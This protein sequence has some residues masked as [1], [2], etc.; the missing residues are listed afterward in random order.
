[1]E[2]DSDKDTEVEIYDAPENHLP[3]MLKSKSR[4]G[5]LLRLPLANYL[6][7]QRGVPLK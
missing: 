5:E 7:F 3:Q 1:M 6:V 4:A 2:D